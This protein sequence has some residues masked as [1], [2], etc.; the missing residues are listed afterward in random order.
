M[1]CISNQYILLIEVMLSQPLMSASVFWIQ[2]HQLTS[3]VD[4]VGFNYTWQEGK[5]IR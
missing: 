2:F 5:S 4:H 1:F 3:W